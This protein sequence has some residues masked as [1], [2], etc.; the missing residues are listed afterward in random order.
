MRADLICFVLMFFLLSVSVS[1]VDY[2]VDVNS[3]GGSCNDNNN[4]RSLDSPWC[5]ITRANS[6]L[7]AGDTV[8]IR[9]GIYSTNDGG[10][11]INPDNDGS[12]GNPITYTNYQNEEAILRSVT[13]ESL[14]KGAQISRNYITID[15]LKIDNIDQTRSKMQ[16][17]I[18]SASNRHHIIIKNCV[19]RYLEEYWEGFVNGI[20]IG[21]GAQ[22]WQIL[23]NTISHV[24]REGYTDG[25]DC[26]KF[27]ET[28]SVCSS[29]YNLIEGNTISYCSHSCINTQGKFNVIR[30]NNIQNRWEKGL[31]VIGSAGDVNP[32][33]DGA[34]NVF[35]GNMLHN[36]SSDYGN[37]HGVGLQVARS[38]RNIVRRN[39]FYE[40]D[41]SAFSFR[42]NSVRSGEENKFYNNVLYYNG[43][44]CEGIGFQHAIRC[45]D[46]DD[47]EDIDGNVLKNNLLYDNRYNNIYH[48]NGLSSNADLIIAN[49][50]N[51]GVSDGNPR[52]VNQ[53]NDDFRLQ[54][55]SPCIDAGGWLTA[56]R[57]AGSGTNI[58]VQDASYFMDGFGI[59][60]GDLIQ[61]QG[62]SQ[63]ARITN[64]D[65]STNTITVNT[66]LTWTSGQGVSLSY[67]GSAPDIGA[68]EYEGTPTY[69]C[70]D[71]NCDPGEDCSSCPQDC[72]CVSPEICCSGICSTPT[73]S[74]NSDC[75]SDPC[76]TYT[77]SNPGTCSSACSSQ[78]KTSCVNDDGCCPSG[79]T[80]QNDND[81]LP[82][83]GPVAFWHFDE[84]SGDLAGDSSGNANQGTI[85]GAAWTTGLSGSAL[86][87]D[88]VNDYVSVPENDI[89]DPSEIT[90]DAWV[91][92]NST[93]TINGNM[94][95]KGANNGYRFLINTARAIW[96]GDRGNTNSVKTTRLVP[97]NE[98]T[99]I[100]VVGSS[101]GLRIYING[102]LD[103]SNSV[104]YGGPN[105]DNT[106]EIGAEPA[107]SGYFNGTI[108]EVRIYDRALTPGEIMDNYN[109]LAEMARADIDKDGDVD[110]DDLIEIS[111]DFGKTSGYDPDADTNSDGEVDI[112]DVVFVAS[113]FS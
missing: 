91:R 25:G 41:A 28:D 112:F 110:I 19:F 7:Q 32:A 64:V 58:P 83:G 6:L 21:D 46:E 102:E 70:G 76:K 47:Q 63:T 87:F 54:T 43:W 99:H 98:W 48:M 9:A 96:F 44:N 53:A 108:D 18:N 37:A 24:G 100:T 105:T 20:K 49:N 30:N 85:Q 10:A 13:D 82:L 61:L 111:L 33:T 1:A 86:S 95:A 55:D 75:G 45:S 88:G 109:E 67:S 94:V 113:R 4:G 11:I 15:G 56:T 69:E 66:P 26:I 29:R 78:D 79:C 12:S 104:P 93:P 51:F 106:L 50:W 14:D 72:S 60:E 59:V 81:C 62:Q 103:A 42:G 5:T 35:E 92:I 90:I 3:I 16:H 101:S 17:F 34:Y 74:Q 57:S 31:D 89:L 22:Y 80:D 8:Y 40:N 68:Y 2:Y 73:C 71:G 52:F 84:G 107:F 27:Q 38:M 77:C 36:C 97:L 23:N 65:Y 39:L